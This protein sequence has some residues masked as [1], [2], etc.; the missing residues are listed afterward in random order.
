MWLIH[1]GDASDGN[2]R[3]FGVGFKNDS[4]S[5]IDLDS[6]GSYDTNL[7]TEFI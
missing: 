6:S 2:N 7:I 1:N 4:V 3:I 5:I